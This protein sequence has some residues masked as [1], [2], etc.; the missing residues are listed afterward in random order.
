MAI[1]TQPLQLSL[2]SY[3]SLQ[4]GSILQTA[5]F[6]DCCTEINTTMRISS[7]D[8][9]SREHSPPMADHRRPSTDEIFPGCQREPTRLLPHI[10]AAQNQ[11]TAKTTSYLCHSQ[12]IYSV[13]QKNPSSRFSYNF[14]QTVVTF[15]VQ[16]LHAYYTFLSMLDYKLLFNELQLRRSYAILIAT[17]QFSLYVQ[18]VH[19]RPKCTLAFSDIFPKQLGIFSPTFIY[20][21]H[22]P[23][24]TRL[25]TFIQLSP[26]VM[27]SCH[28][29]CDHPACVSANGGHF[30]HIMVV[31]LNVA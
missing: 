25:Q 9:W 23:I 31:A 24:Y 28:I 27:K 18:N 5:L 20:L 22:D 29:K 30:E 2:K 7:E 19:H 13:I 4:T 11:R 12:S 17:T 15:L 16:I 14:Y 21:L 1:I 6:I 8:T 3:F 26:T 10:L